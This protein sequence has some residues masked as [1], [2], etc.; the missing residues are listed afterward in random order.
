[1]KNKAIIF[2]IDGTA[3]DSP[4]QKLPTKRLIRAAQDIEN[5]YFLCAA[6]G[7]VWSFAEPVLQGLNLVDPCIISA[8]TQLCDPTTGKILWQSNIERIDMQVVLNILK[9]YPDYK[10]LFNDYDEDAYLNGGLEVS[11]LEINET[12]YFF[13]QIFVP[14][15]IASTIVDELSE[16]KRIAVT[17]VVAQRPGF[18]DIHIT[19]KSATKEHAIKELLKV[20]SVEKDNTIGVGDGHNDIHLFAAVHEK[21]A[22]A[23]AVAELKEIADKVIGPVTEDGFA[24]YLESLVA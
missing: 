7:R 14:E 21:V 11:D 2:D 1:M 8:G 18:N 12:V 4:S 17:K 3:I 9:K 19:N 22:M 10:V 20:I 23:N 13:E 6:T 5:E 15:N 24:K 16:I